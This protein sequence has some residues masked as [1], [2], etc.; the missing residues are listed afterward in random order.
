MEHTISFPGLGLEFTMNRVAVSLFGHNIYWYGVIIAVGFLLAVLYCYRKCPQFGVD[1]E[2]LIDM[3]FF[4]VP[5]AIIGARLYYVIFYLSRFQNADGS[6]D[7]GRVIA[8]WDGGL[9]IYG[10]I[11]AAV[12]TVVIFCK[13]R[14]IKLWNF[15]DVGAYGLLIGQAI[16]RW[17]NFVNVE[18]FGGVTDVPWRM[19]GESIADW[20]WKNGHIDSAEVYQSILDGS[21]GVHPTFFYESLWNVIGL[22]LLIVIGNKWRKCDGQI[23]L[24][25]IA[26]YGV[27]RAVIE[28]IRTDTLFFFNTGIKVSQMLAILSAAA[29]VVLLV[30]R[31]KNSGPATAALEPAQEEE[32][33]AEKEEQ[34]QEQETED[35][36]Q[37]GE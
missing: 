2:K 36:T 8:I 22:V 35:E 26:W 15:L 24:S 31:M 3:L 21:L 13:V 16:G 5:L 7:W 34:E 12:A 23:F 32:K 37:D 4:A 10:G 9:A 17:G 28:G 30:W 18:V 1:S 20:L 14:K 11:I 29:A 33:E 27:G 6:L 19:C 25:Y